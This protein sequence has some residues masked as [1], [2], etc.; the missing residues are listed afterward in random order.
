MS[1]LASSVFTCHILMYKKLKLNLRA[2]VLFNLKFC[3]LFTKIMALA[4]LK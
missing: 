4:D 3:S 2:A 1:N